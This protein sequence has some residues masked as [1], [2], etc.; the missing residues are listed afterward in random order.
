[1]SVDTRTPTHDS[2]RA[3]ME[4]ATHPSYSWCMRCGRPWRTV[5][6]HVTSY[7]AA[8]GCFPLCKGCWE[9]LGSPEARIE[10]YAML[11]DYWAGL[12]CPIDEDEKRAMQIAVA[13]GG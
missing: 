6:E 12:G 5:E 4:R 8:K 10:Y 9:L 2:L 1:M 13:N 7:T 11:I 3:R